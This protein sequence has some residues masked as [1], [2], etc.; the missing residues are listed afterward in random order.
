MFSAGQA[1]A[2]LSRYCG[3]SA[4]SYVRL[5]QEKR[6]G[7]K[8]RGKGLLMSGLSFFFS[9]RKHASL[10]KINNI[11]KRLHLNYMHQFCLM[12]NSCC[13]KICPVRIRKGKISALLRYLAKTTAL[14]IYS[15]I[16]G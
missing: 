13:D 1:V 9:A 12:Q 8:S 2:V 14:S 6:P 16:L 3:C 5:L 4:C 15:I 10:K 11:K 7:G